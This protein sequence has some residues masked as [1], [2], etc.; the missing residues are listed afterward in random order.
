MA[1]REVTI[2]RRRIDGIDVLWCIFKLR[3]YLLVVP[4]IIDIKC[5]TC[6]GMFD[7]PE[8]RFLD[9]RNIQSRITKART[10]NLSFQSC[11]LLPLHFAYA[12][13]LFGNILYYALAYWVH[14]LYLVH[15]G[16]VILRFAF[17]YFMYCKR[18]YSDAR[19]VGVGVMRYIGLEIAILGVGGVMFLTLWREL[20]QRLAEAD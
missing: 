14:F 11:A 4:A 12:S 1:L 18:F 2:Q 6:T 19:I 20:K 10:R 16:R 17:I 3:Y 5:R 15:I 9:P 13:T 7:Q 8:L